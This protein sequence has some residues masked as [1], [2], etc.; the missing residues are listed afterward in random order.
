MGLANKPAFPDQSIK[1]GT[2]WILR[3]VDEASNHFTEEQF[4]VRSHD[5]MKKRMEPLGRDPE[6][7]LCMPNL[8]RGAL[9]QVESE[10]ELKGNNQT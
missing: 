7:A 10:G 2:K 3:A 1:I 5:G 4:Y 6:Q 8:K 9:A